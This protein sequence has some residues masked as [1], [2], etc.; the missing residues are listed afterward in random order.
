MDEDGIP[1]DSPPFELESRRCQGCTLMAAE[2]ENLSKHK[3]RG[4]YLYFKKA[5]KG[6]SSRE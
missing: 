5:M 1:F 3:E 2:Q 4:V 6:F